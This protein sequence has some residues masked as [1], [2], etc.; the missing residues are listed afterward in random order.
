[1]DKSK[2]ISPP[3]QKTKSQ[4]LSKILSLFL[5]LSLTITLYLHLLLASSLYLPIISILV[6]SLY[7]TA[8][9]FFS[10]SLTLLCN[11]SFFTSLELPIFPL[12]LSFLFPSISFKLLKSFLPI[13]KAERDRKPIYRKPSQDRPASNKKQFDRSTTSS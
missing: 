2:T 11:P 9:P 5:F 8:D 7:P 13:S 12:S 3:H 1:M 4:Q 10:S 6:F